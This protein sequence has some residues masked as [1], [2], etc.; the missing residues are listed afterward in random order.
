MQRANANE[1]TDFERRDPISGFP[2]YKALLCDVVKRVPDAAA[3]GEPDPALLEK[4]LEVRRRL[5]A[6]DLGEG[7]A[8]PGW[9]AI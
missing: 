7:V 5:V 9:P 6:A 3:Y 2:V 8:T 4:L 1:L